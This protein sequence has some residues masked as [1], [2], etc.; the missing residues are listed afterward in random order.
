MSDPVIESITE[1]VVEERQRFGRTKR[2]V[3]TSA[4]AV[5]VVGVGFG[6]SS[7][8]AATKSTTHATANRTGAR[9]TTPN[10]APTAVGTVQSIDAANN[11]FTIQTS[12][13]TDTVNVSSS[14]TYRDFDVSSPSLSN[15]TVGENVAVF[16]TASG[17]TISATSVGIGVPPHGG[18]G[19]AGCVAMAGQRA[20]SA[21]GTS[22][23]TN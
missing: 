4:L 7:A 3:A 2:F 12:S 19:M 14:T 11:A 23:T 6:A 8:F 9:A 17:T 13:A 15:V 5:S 1:P 21:S 18:G 20:A 10:G 16:G 22:G